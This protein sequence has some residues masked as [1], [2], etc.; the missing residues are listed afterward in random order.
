MEMGVEVLLQTQLR[1]G[2]GLSDGVVG[3]KAIESR[4]C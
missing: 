4:V 3:M 1:V 2:V